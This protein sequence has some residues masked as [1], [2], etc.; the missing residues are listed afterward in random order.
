MYRIPLSY[1][2]VDVAQLSAVLL[3]YSNR[4]HQDIVHD[5]EKELAALTGA[6]YVVALNSGTAAIH[7]ALKALHVDRDDVVIV[8]TFTYV[9]SVNPVLYQGAKP[10]FVDSE[11]DTWNIDPVLV[12]QAILASPR[13]PKAI[14]VVHNYG[15]P[16]KLAELKQ[17][18]E[19]YSIPLVEDAAEAVGSRY[20]GKHVGTFGAVGVLS[21]NNNKVMTTYGGGAVLTDNENIFEKVKFWASQAREDKLYYEHRE[22]G[23]NYRMSPL[24]AAAG[25]ANLPGLTERVEKRRRDFERYR[26]ALGIPEQALQPDTDSSYSNRW[27]STVQL[28][29]AGNPSVLLDEL[30]KWGIETRFFWKPMHCQ[31]LFKN[32]QVQVVGSRV[33]ENLFN[34]GIC[35]PSGNITSDQLEEIITLSLPYFTG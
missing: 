10:L 29:E 11:N 3:R 24:N 15:F 1:T 34:R 8:P 35:L 19:K 32:N 4:H 31:P 16:A 33:S 5:F 13:K 28:P 2:P 18:S 6:K 12:E 30:G 21:F 23:Y 22:V 20:Q 27:F 25:L 9:A 7:L 17:I 26:I 14:V